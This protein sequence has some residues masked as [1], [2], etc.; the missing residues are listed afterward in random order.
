VWYTIPKLVGTNCGGTGWE[1][2]VKRSGLFPA[3]DGFGLAEEKRHAYRR[4]CIVMY[5][6][7][8]SAHGVNWTGEH[9]LDLMLDRG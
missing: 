7:F 4:I 5:G 2:V 8:V 9:V 1:L 3:A 6:R